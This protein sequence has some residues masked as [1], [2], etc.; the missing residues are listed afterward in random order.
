LLRQTSVYA[1][2]YVYV[3]R[4]I[5]IYIYVFVYIYIY[6]S[7]PTFYSHFCPSNIALLRLP[8]RGQQQQKPTPSVVVTVSI[9][10]RQEESTRVI[11]MA[12]ACLYPSSTRA[13]GR[14]SVESES[15]DYGKRGQLLRRL[16]GWPRDW[17][18]PRA[19]NNT[20]LMAISQAEVRAIHLCH[21]E[22]KTPITGR[23]WRHA[24]GV[25]MRSPMKRSQRIQWMQ[26]ILHQS[27]HDFR[28]SCL[29]KGRLEQIPC[30]DICSR[31]VSVQCRACL[32]TYAWHLDHAL[33]TYL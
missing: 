17:I 19:I 12:A 10:K 28:Y 30:P 11:L 9:I 33:S 21:L 14:P 16:R 7:C 20:A 6:M 24:R 8:S 5:Y 4:Y 1:Y 3:H 22:R 31:V 32:S 29:R 18:I 27:V 13:G 15:P 23:R 2:M 26:I 25:T